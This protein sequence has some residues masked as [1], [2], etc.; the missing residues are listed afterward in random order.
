MIINSEIIPEKFKED[1]L[2]NGS[3]VIRNF[4]IEEYIENL[5]HFFSVSMP[6]DWWYSSSCPGTEGKVKYIRNIDTNIDHINIEKDFAEKVFNEGGYS[7]HFYRSIGDH[8]ASCQC[9]E[10]LFREW[11]KS[12]EIITFLKK[13][14]GFE[15][16]TFNT[17][18]AS[19]Y[20]SGC[21]LGPHHDDSL[22]KIGFVLQL[23]KN[24]KPQW[25]GILHFLNDDLDKITYSEVPTFNTLTLFHIPEGSGKWHYVS[26]VSPGIKSNRIAYSG[27]YY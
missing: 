18:F 11:L 9:E 15:I 5:N 10:C 3:V 22:G 26:H 1:F 24:W 23:T 20:T 17:M 19:K 8:Y 2:K 6:N 14:S 21:F 12:D 13:V 4:L 16:T 7:Y 27:W 25:G